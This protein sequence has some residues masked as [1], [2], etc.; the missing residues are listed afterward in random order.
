MSPSSSAKQILSTVGSA[1]ATALLMRTIINEYLP[2]EIY[3]F[4][5]SRIR[6]LTNNFS[7]QLCMVIEE[8]EGFEINKVFEAAEIYLGNKESPSIKRIK[9][10]KSDKEKDFTVTMEPY[11][12]LVDIFQEAKFVWKLV[13]YVP[14][15][16]DVNTARPSSRGEVKSFELSFHKKHKDLILKSYLPHIMEQVKAIKEERSLV[17][18]HTLNRDF[19][20]QD[21]GSVWDH[22]IF[23]HPAT[24]DTLAI[25]T[26]LKEEIMAD[27]K[28]FTERKDFYRR[29][30][31]AWKRG[32]LLYGPPGTGKS[33]LV[34]AMA[35]FLN[36]D[37]YDLEL[38]A[39]NSNSEFRKLLVAI[40][41]RSI[42]VIEDI[43]RTVDL[44]GQSAQDEP[45]NTRNLAVCE[46]DTAKTQRVTLSGLLNFLDG[47]WSTC[48]DET[49][50]VFTT[51][52][53]EKLDPALLR[54]GRMDKHILLGYCKFFSFK[55]LVS[56]YH[57]VDEH[58]LFEEVAGLLEEAEVTPAEVGEQLIR[59]EDV[60]IAL[61]GLIE[62]LKKKREDIAQ[63]KEGNGTGIESL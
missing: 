21:P 63:R 7:S 61:Q 62:V 27:L 33:S 54:P 18:L 43:D 6:W 19:Y 57:G 13:S 41:N 46:P 35:N 60:G 4:I 29:V 38:A 47:L 32:Y 44:E 49:I 56:T 34:A 8:F 51:N 1:A 2:P 48:A 12:Q 50:F 52:H 53:K 9:V 37:V 36:F 11:E 25:D 42:I 39:I 45:D 58:P 22:I 31:K 3:D 59:S 23:D 24:F 28:R 17:K 55:K 5:S 20:Y 10:R 15:Q 26:T 14:Q 16:A 40:A 30:G